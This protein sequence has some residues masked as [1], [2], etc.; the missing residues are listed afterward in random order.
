MNLN[1]IDW[2]HYTILIAE[3]E[4][5][6]Y[7]FFEEILEDTR[8][9]IIWVTNGQEAVNY[10]EKNNEIDLVL[11]DIKMPVLNGYDATRIIKKNRP[12]LPI[13]AQT[14]YALV[15]DDLKAREAGCDD[16]IYKPINVANLI[17]K[18]SKFLK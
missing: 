15:G 1:K 6:N 18:I 3:D 10:C 12:D 4:V 14:A 9:N 13:I 2:S 16:Y 8:V 11:M 5:I 17:E 7:Q